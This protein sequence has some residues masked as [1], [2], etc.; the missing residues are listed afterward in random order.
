MLEE[1]RSR[2]ITR[3]GNNDLPEFAKTIRLSFL[4]NM[5]LPKEVYSSN[6]EVQVESGI[7]MFQQI[8]VNEKKFMLFSESGCGGLVSSHDAVK[9]LGHNSR[10]I[11]KG[12]ISIGGIGGVQIESLYGVH[13]VSLPLHNG[14][15]A[16]VTGVVIDEVTSEFPTYNLDTNVESDIHRA[17]KEHGGKVKD[18]PKLPKKVGSKVHFMI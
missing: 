6:H 1:Y 15:N 12:P 3:N 18:L 9:R 4:S 14:K 7:Y 10:Q 17:Y 16:V 8:M 5:S 2:C 13:E 11:T